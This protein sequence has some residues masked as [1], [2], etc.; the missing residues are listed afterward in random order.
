MEKSKQS[1]YTMPFYKKFLYNIKSYIITKKEEF[2]FPWFGAIFFALMALTALTIVLIIQHNK[3]GIVVRDP[4]DKEGF[5]YL[6]TELDGKSPEDYNYKTYKLSNNKFEF[7]L[8]E[9]TTQFTLFDK[10]VSTTYMSN[11]IDGANDVLVLYYAANL[12]NTKSYGTYTYSVSQ[13]NYYIKK[14]DE[15]SLE[16][17]YVLGRAGISLDS[18][19]YYLT[20]EEKDNLAAEIKNNPKLGS[21]AR[22]TFNEAY[23]NYEDDKDGNRTYYLL[24]DPTKNTAKNLYDIFYGGEGVGLGWTKEQVFEWNAEDGVYYDNENTKFEV[25]V[26]YTLHDDRFEARVVNDAF[27]ETEENPIIGV[28]FLPYFN[29]GG[30]NDE[31][32]IVI[33]DGSGVL[34]NFNNG[35]EANAYDKRI[36]GED[37]GINQYYMKETSENINMPLFGMKNGNNNILAVVSQG[38]SMTNIYA[39]SYTSKFKY[40]SANFKFYLREGLDYIFNGWNSEQRVTGW[41]KSYVTEDFVVDYYFLETDATYVDMANKAKELFV[42]ENIDNTNELKLDINVLGAYK[43]NV[44]VFGIPVTKVDSL[45]NYSEIDDIVNSFTGIDDINIYYEGM[46]NDGLTNYALEK[47]KINKAMGNKSQVADLF[48]EYNGNYQIY[49]SV[50]LIT[51]Y[52]S[53]KFNEKDYAVRDPFSDI[54]E[55]YAYDEATWIPLTTAE[56]RYTIKASYV[57]EYNA[58]VLESLTNVGVNAI[59]I[60]DMGNILSGSYRNKD[61]EFR[62]EALEQYLNVLKSYKENNYKI[63]ASNPAI[64]MFD[65]ITSANGIPYTGTKYLVVDEVIPFYQLVLSGKVDYSP[66]A[67]NMNEAYSLDYHKLKLIETGSNLNFTLTYENTDKLIKTDYNKYFNCWYKYYVE[68][69]QKLYDELNSIGYAAGYLSNH[70]I[71]DENVVKVTYSNGIEIVLNYSNKE[72]EGVNPMSYSVVKGGN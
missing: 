9:K 68:K 8:D 19:P 52:T 18:F 17:I 35:K 32:Y 38:A 40:N 26:R 7:E 71:L 24:I 10:E 22:A 13:N 37:T 43:K 25:C 48:E 4:Y 63:S 51:T 11:P 21:K 2:K 59:N 53:E 3:I 36:Y 14:I 56:P 39:K 15:K 41:T 16:V 57:N 55:R 70:E 72:Y 34:I 66:N 1:Y 44:S 46:F 31:G 47:I 20:K 33:P 27:V 60:L 5:K 54:V 12:G 30:K 6:Y 67:I 42:P 62:S 58:N 50:N 45:T 61:T 65:Y 49:S 64:Y 23:K 28:D 29:A 69:I